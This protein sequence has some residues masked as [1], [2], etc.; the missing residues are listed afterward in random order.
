MSS[1]NPQRTPVGIVSLV[2]ML[3]HCQASPEGLVPAA[4]KVGQDL[5]TRPFLTWEEQLATPGVSSPE[6]NGNLEGHPPLTCCVQEE[7]TPQAA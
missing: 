1:S 6:G 7:V 2:W 5:L 4:S 3:L